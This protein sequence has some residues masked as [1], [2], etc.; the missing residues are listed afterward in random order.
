ME[1]EQKLK[2]NTNL[3]E[4]N[5]PFNIFHN[6]HE[7][8]NVLGLHWHDNNEILFM[9]EG[10][11]VFY[12][13]SQAAEAIPGDILFVNSGQLHSGYSLDH[14]RVVYDAVVFHPSLLANQSPDPYQLKYISPFIDG[15]WAFPV[16]IGRD[17]AE[18]SL[19]QKP[20]Q[21]LISEFREK[22]PGHELAIKSL[23]IQMT[24]AVYRGFYAGGKNQD[25]YE[26]Y[27]RETERFKK[28]IT[29]IAQKYDQKISVQEAA[30]IVNL[31]PTYFCKAFKRATGR[32][33]VEYLNLYRVNV[34]AEMLRIGEL[35]VTE[36]AS[37]IGFCNI[38]Y[39]DKVFKQ[40][41]KVTPSRFK[42]A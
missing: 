30:A 12:I 19:Y 41:K 10:H 1:K 11:A 39:F 38:N 33:F 8:H 7:E 20:L 16:K 3:M 2:E 32:S 22:Q 31:S 5:F 42:N 15:H 9:H 13:D 21:S 25:V 28:L 17:S 35:P 37:K 4:M 18:Y 24:V 27:A 23:L 29:H 34:A 26:P 40:Y 14:R 36:I 6:R